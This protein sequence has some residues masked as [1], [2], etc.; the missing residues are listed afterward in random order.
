MFKLHDFYCP[1]CQLILEALIKIPQGKKPPRSLR[2]YCTICNEDRNF[3]WQVPTKVAKYYGDRMYSPR[4]SGGK[5]DTLGAERMPSYPNGIPDDIS[6][7]DFASVC[8]NPEWREITAERKNISKRNAAKR[9]RAKAIDKN[10]ETVSVRTHPLPG[11]P[12]F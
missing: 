1:Q 11:D 2:R 7:D 5:F 9:A 6:L 8:R 3:K 12:R 10:P 4:V